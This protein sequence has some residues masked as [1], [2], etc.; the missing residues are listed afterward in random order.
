MVQTA[1]KHESVMGIGSR[2]YSDLDD[3]LGAGD[4]HVEQVA[5]LTMKTHAT[6]WG[7]LAVPILAFWLVYQWPAPFN[8]RDAYERPVDGMP[9]TSVVASYKVEFS[10][11]FGRSSACQGTAVRAFTDSAGRTWPM[12]MTG[13]SYNRGTN[14]LAYTMVVPRDA[15]PGDGVLT[16]HLDWSCNWIQAKLGRSHDLPDLF[17]SVAPKPKD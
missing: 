5:P 13:L 9:G 16:A 14:D 7:L 10:S 3:H 2:G 12:G 17:F 6:I 11:D 4:R 15:A 8:D 1:Q